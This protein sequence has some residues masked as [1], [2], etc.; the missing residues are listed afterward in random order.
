MRLNSKQQ[1]DEA[2]FAIELVIRTIMSHSPHEHTEDW[3]KAY[4]LLQEAQNILVATGF[5]SEEFD[6]KLSAY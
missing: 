3:K 2:G 5:Y 1:N 4:R 6:P